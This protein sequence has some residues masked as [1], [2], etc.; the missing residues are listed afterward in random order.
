MLGIIG[1]LL[2]FHVVHGKQQLH[3]LLLSLFHHLQSVIQLIRLAQGVA[4]LLALGLGKGVSHAAADDQGVYF[5]QQ[6][7]DHVDLV[8]NL[9]AAQDGNEGTDRILNSLAQELDLLL[10]QIANHVLLGVFGN[11][12]VGAVGSVSGS[13]GVV[14]EHAAVAQISQFFRISF[15]SGVALFVLG[16]LNSV[17]GVLKQQNLAVL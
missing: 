7:V 12:N 1:E 6:V 14:H 17:A 16:L 15:R 11:A 4:D 5:I 9:G 3:A 10:H 8:R 13:E 2:A